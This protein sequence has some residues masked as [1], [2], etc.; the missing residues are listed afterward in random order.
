MI[1]PFDDTY[2][3][4]KALQEAQDAF[5]QGEIP[6]GAIIVIKTESS[7]EHTT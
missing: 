7:R 6:V 2:Y 1:K 3:M 5:D 4:K